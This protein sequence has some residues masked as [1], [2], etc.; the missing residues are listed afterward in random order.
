[1][2]GHEIIYNMRDTMHRTGR[3]IWREIGRGFSRRIRRMAIVVGSFSLALAFPCGAYAID[4]AKY[5]VLDSFISDMVTSHGLERDELNTIFASAVYK[6]KIIQS[7]KRP[8]ERLT[9]AKYRPLFV[10]TDGGRKG[11]AF[12]EAHLADFE[13]A[14]QEFGV[15]VE[16]I[17]AIMGVET[18]YGKSKGKHRIIDSLTTLT[19]GYPRRS[20]FFKRE[21]KEFLLLSK[22]EG[23]DPLALKGSYAGAM[24][25]PQFLSSSYRAYGID[26]SGDSKR[27]LL[28]TPADAIGSIGNY[29]KKRGWRRG[30]LIAVPA[31]VAA[32][33]DGKAL[34]VS[35]RKPDSTANKLKAA[36]VKLQYTSQ[37]NPPVGLI[38]L[39]GAS[40]IEYRGAFKNFFAIMTYNPSKLYAMAVYELSQEIG[41]NR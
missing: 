10:T 33:V 30:E 19:V 12:I 28:N 13:R 8:A 4:V 31:S 9:W 34:A 38:R 29:L 27:D 11:A 23:F 15:P 20:K 16:V 37:D 35:G 39:N 2:R 26:F 3:E 21:L 1:M 7:M 32:G 24:G 5:P 25:I 36:G 6:P 40:G 17:A 18:R 14:E 41:R 22:E